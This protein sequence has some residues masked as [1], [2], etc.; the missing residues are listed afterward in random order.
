VGIWSTTDL[1]E[2][3]SEFILHYFGHT[4]CKSRRSLTLL[5]RGLLLCS[6]FFFLS[7][8]KWGSVL[9]SRLVPVHSIKCVDTMF[10]SYLLTI[11]HICSQLLIS[12]FTI[13][14]IL[15][16][17]SYLL[18]QLLISASFTCNYYSYLLLLITQLSAKIY[19]LAYNF[20][21]NLVQCPILGYRNRLK[22]FYVHL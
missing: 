12:A 4:Y 16:N 19:P 5:L 6:W 15:Y 11:A 22:A 18:S 21:R 9:C 20:I 10:C 3:T 1:I 13:A 14:H 7:P 8:E 2:C 17:C